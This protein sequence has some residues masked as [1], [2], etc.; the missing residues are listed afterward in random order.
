[1]HNILYF[2]NCRLQETPMDK[3]IKPF[4]SYILQI[5]RT[6]IFIYF[7]KT[8]SYPHLYQLI[9]LKYIFSRKDGTVHQALPQIC[10]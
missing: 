4:T 9:F 8:I 3:F 10:R 6:S 2:P 5:P 7:N 1:M